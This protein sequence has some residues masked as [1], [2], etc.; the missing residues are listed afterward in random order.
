MMMFIKAERKADFGLH[1]HCCKMMMPYFFAARHFNYARF[2]TCYI[3]TM[4]RLPSDVQF[5]WKKDAKSA[6]LAAVMMPPNALPAPDSVLKS[7]SCN[8]DVSQCKTLACKCRKNSR[9][10]TDFCK[11][12]ESKCHNDCAES[13]D[14]DASDIDDL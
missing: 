9:P 3:N 12:S 2:G 8:C 6:T 5:G 1:L 11:C 7:I 10:C 13:S 4:E 14:E